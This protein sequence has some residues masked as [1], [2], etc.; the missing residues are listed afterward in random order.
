M[1]SPLEA[2]RALSIQICRDDVLKQIGYKNPPEKNLLHLIDEMLELGNKYLEPIM[3]FKAVALSKDLPLFLHGA[4]LS[5]IA[6]AS[7]GPALEN[8]SKAF[9]DLG[10]ATEGYLLDIVGSV[11]VMHVGNALWAK[12]IEDAA[13]RGFV[14]RL[15][16][17]PGCEGVPMEVQKWI[18][19]RFHDP[20]MGVHV[21]PSYMLVPRKSFAFLG[22]FGGKLESVFSCKDCPQFLNCDLRT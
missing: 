15:R 21:T 12:M 2:P 9:F 18:V 5:Y 20:H 6:L 14:K 17:A 4:A 7:I 13:L 11:A 16:R 1:C 19:E 8:R 3:R 10:R 22:R